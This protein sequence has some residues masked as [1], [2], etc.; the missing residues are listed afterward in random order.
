MWPTGISIH[1]VKAGQTFQE[2]VE[3]L[4]GRPVDPGE[5]MT[6]LTAELIRVAPEAVTLTTAD[7]DHV[8]GVA[9]PVH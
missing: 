7:I 4:L 9:G 8:N 3:E 5:K 2:R 6:D 1:K